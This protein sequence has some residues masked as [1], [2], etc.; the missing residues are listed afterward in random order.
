[1]RIAAITLLA[2]SIGWLAGSEIYSE[3]TAYPGK[4]IWSASAPASPPVIF[5]VDAL[6][7]AVPGVWGESLV[8]EMLNRI[9]NRGFSEV[10]WVAAATPQRLEYPSTAHA[11]RVVNYPAWGCD[12]AEV[13]LPAAALRE[14][15][16]LNLKLRF[17]VP[18]SMAEDFRSRYPEAELVTA[19]PSG[20]RLEKLSWGVSNFPS[21]TTELSA[22]FTVG[23]EPRSGEIWAFIHGSGVLELNGTPIARLDGNRLMRRVAVGPMLK[24]GDNTVTIR[25]TRDRNDPLTGVIAGVLWEDENGKHELF[26]DETWRAKFN[27]VDVATAVTGIDR[28]GRRFMLRNLA[29]AELTGA[30]ERL[31]ELD[32]LVRPIALTL[33]GKAVKAEEFRVL[34]DGILTDKPNLRTPATAVLEFDFGREVQ[35]EKLRIY[36]G[37]IGNTGNASTAMNL[38]AVRLEGSPASGTSVQ[39][40]E[41]LQL[42]AATPGDTADFHCEI[43]FKPVRIRR[44]RISAL[45]SSDSGERLNGPVTPKQRGIYWREIEFVGT[46]T[47]PTNSTRR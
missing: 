25:G 8:F 12:F 30:D 1:M 26:S 40:A 16:A 41:E 4:W 11:D 35:L 5:Q 18:E 22:D 2:L 34:F 24:T 19:P 39:L 37:Y 46:P 29:D 28:G 31:L 14:A 44:L 45:E 6:I 38:A 23:K 20:H 42:P 33:N 9:A 43:K 13:D 15:G 10:V 36:S 32:R 27:G 47:Q 17:F 7:R 3:Y 21:G